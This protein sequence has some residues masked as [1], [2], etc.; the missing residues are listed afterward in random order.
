MAGVGQYDKTLNAGQIGKGVIGA[1]VKCSQ[2]G[3]SRADRYIGDV[4]LVSQVQGRARPDID[5]TVIDE[6]ADVDHIVRVVQIQIG[7]LVIGE[8][9]GYV[10]R[11]AGIVSIVPAGRE[12]HGVV[13]I[14]TDIAV[15]AVAKVQE[16]GVADRKRAAV[17]CNV[18]GLT[19]VLELHIPLDAGQVGQAARAV[20]GRAQGKGAGQE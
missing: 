16:S 12:E 7:V 13:D 19:V 10:H 11:A 9:A 2:F 5:V 15:G 20:G 8:R 6:G 14:A 1:S 3:V 17:G 18:V 4:E